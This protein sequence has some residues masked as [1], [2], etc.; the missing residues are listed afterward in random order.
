MARFQYVAFSY[1]WFQVCICMLHGK[2][3]KCNFFLPLIFQYI[4]AKRRGCKMLPFLP[5]LRM[6]WGGCKMLPLPL[7]TSCLIRTFTLKDVWWRENKMLFIQCFGV[8]GVRPFWKRIQISGNLV[9]SNIHVNI[10]KSQGSIFRCRL[11]KTTH[12]YST[13]NQQRF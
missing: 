8:A 4:G 13:I 9:Y 11:T 1:P 6:R 3:A 5:L 12:P 10:H 2:V 7:T